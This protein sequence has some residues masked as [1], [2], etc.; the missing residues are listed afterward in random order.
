[1]LTFYL[2]GVLLT[3]LI[4]L[5]TQKHHS[6][7]VSKIL[8]FMGIIFPPVSIAL[9]IFI[10]LANKK[11]SKATKNQKVLFSP[12]P[13][14]QYK[15]V[16][17]LFLSV[18]VF[19]GNCFYS[20][21]PH[22]YNDVKIIPLSII[23]SS[24]GFVYNDNG[25]SDAAIEEIKQSGESE[26]DIHFID[27]GQGDSIFITDGNKKVLVDA[28]T[29]NAGNEVVDYIQN[30]GVGKIHLVV[31]THPHADHIGGLG[32]V[33]N[34]FQVKKVW[35]SGQSHTS[36]TYQSYLQ[37]IE[38]NNIDFLIVDA[39][40]KKELGNYS[41]KVLG[42]NQDED[43]E[44]LNNNSIVAK[45][46]HGEITALLT[47]D[48]EK[49][50]ENALLQSERCLNS[51]ILKVGHHGS[52][53]STTKE[54]L[55]KVNPSVAVI[56]VGEKNRYGHPHEETL[57]KLMLKDIDIYRND[58]HGNILITSDGAKYSTQLGS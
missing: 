28:G 20:V 24:R 39:G 54:F 25:N 2:I 16:L 41:L 29:Q 10:F 45:L 57:E 58:I 36:A 43:L 33:F 46:K 19:L 23:N 53:T 42:P 55:K 6:L 26:V 8:F 17:L 32:H 31:A 13:K 12:L 21:Q 9:Y 47:G 38:E 14:K 11:R 44:G 3:Y 51:D 35:D 50:G 5:H 49:E 22:L 18:I 34:N 37:S 7:S 1:M 15:A 40:H 56:Q 27:V 52:R 30:L 48:V 4:F